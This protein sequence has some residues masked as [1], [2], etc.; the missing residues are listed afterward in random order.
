MGRA[1]PLSLS[2]NWTMKSALVKHCPLQEGAMNDHEIAPRNLPSEAQV[3]AKLLIESQHSLMH[4][5]LSSPCYLRFP[6]SDIAWKLWR[7]NLFLQSS[8]LKQRKKRV[9]LKN[10]THSP[11]HHDCEPG[12]LTTD[13]YAFAYMKFS[14]VWRIVFVIW[15]WI[16]ERSSS[17]Y[18]TL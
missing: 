16:N 15:L 18:I 13:P 2:S 14:P 4:N 11:I 10:T 9:L 17:V 12:V 6:K 5:S 8:E 7:R 3:W 1:W